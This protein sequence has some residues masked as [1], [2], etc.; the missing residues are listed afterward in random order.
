MATSPPPD[1]QPGVVIVIEPRTERLPWLMIEI[2]AG[3]VGSLI[4]D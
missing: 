3:T 1:A 2:P 4:A